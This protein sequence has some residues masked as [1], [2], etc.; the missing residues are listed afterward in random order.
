[1]K[2]IK[3]LPEKLNE[4]DLIA[5]WKVGE[6][7]GCFSNWYPAKVDNL[8]TSE[9]AMMFE[10]ALLFND[11][12]ILDEITKAKTPAE[13]KALGRKVKNF[14]PK[15]WDS[16]KVKIVTNVLLKKFTQNETLKLILLSTG[17]KVLVEASPLD[18]I[19]G[20]GLAADNPRLLTPL[21]WPG[22]NLLGFCLMEVRNRIRK[23][24]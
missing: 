5:F 6:P 24:V 11:L 1:M 17:D 9:H 13:V 12:E 4:C 19:W 7:W 21:M 22:E 20:I 14:D 18:S 8:P 3:D 16:Q 10:K 23:L 2:S 15:V